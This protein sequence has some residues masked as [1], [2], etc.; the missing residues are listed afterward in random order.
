MDIFGLLPQGSLMLAFKIPLLV[1][2][3]LYT[4]FSFIVLNRV[5]AF[6]RIVQIQSSNASTTIHLFAILYFLLPLSLFLI[7]LVIV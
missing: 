2:L 3:F 4:V 5:K 1:L 7:C 6:N